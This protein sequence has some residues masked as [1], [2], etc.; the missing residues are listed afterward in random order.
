MELEQGPCDSD[1]F[2]SVIL[3]KEETNPILVQN[4]N[5]KVHGFFFSLL[6]S[7][8]S[9]PLG[10]FSHRVAMSVCLSAPSEA[11][12]VN[13]CVFVRVSVCSLLRYRFNVFLPPLPKVGY[14]KILE[15]RNPW[16]KSNGKKLSQIWK[17]LLTNGVKSCAKKVCFWTNFA[18]EKC[19]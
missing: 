3:F 2:I 6:I 14:P 15:L 1:E 11:L 7:I 12:S 10:Q 16:G 9:A 18:W 4:V 17:L 5:G 8:E 19:P 13:R